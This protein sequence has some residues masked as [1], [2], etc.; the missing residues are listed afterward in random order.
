MEP[1]KKWK[2]DR[3]IRLL[4]FDNATFQR[5][6]DRQHA[7]AVQHEEETPTDIVEEVQER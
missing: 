7:L 6:V 4:P 2:E 3:A 1:I 5:E